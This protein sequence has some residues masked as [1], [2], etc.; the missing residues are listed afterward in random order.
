M[1]EF[2]KFFISMIYLWTVSQAVQEPTN[3]RIGGQSVTYPTV[4]PTADVCAKM[5]C[6]DGITAVVRSGKI[7]HDP[8]RFREMENFQKAV[9]KSEE[10]I[11]HDSCPFNEKQKIQKENENLEENIYENQKYDDVG[12]FTTP[13]N[14]CMSFYSY[15]NDDEYFY[16][17]KEGAI[18]LTLPLHFDYNL[19]LFPPY[20]VVFP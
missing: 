16:D 18:H 3:S 14:N 1:L 2:V 11:W 10:K 9:E 13:W 19:F 4:G 5:S 15:Y 12:V 8:C 17:F 6:M 7:G 20:I